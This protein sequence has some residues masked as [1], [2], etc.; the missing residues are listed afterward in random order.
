MCTKTTLHLQYQ[1][2]CVPVVLSHQKP[3]GWLLPHANGKLF[4]YVERRKMEVRIFC[5]LPSAIFIYI[6]LLLLCRF[7]AHC[8]KY[9]VNRFPK[10][11]LVSFSIHNMDK[12]PI[13][14]GFNAVE[15]CNTISFKLIN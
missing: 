5:N 15:D 10:F 7:S 9:T 8:C 4:C 13:I 12:L 1:M 3:Y 6:Y 2:I 14:I 11:Y